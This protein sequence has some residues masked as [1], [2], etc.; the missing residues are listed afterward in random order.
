MEKRETQRI[1][2]NIN[3][4]QVHLVVHHLSEYI[5][6]DGIACGLLSEQT[7]ESL[8][9]DFKKLWLHYQVKDVDSP[10]YGRNLLK[11]IIAYNSSHV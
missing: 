3:V 11:A 7:G 10:M 9:S 4:N 6:Q 1:N 8:H 5:E 2:F